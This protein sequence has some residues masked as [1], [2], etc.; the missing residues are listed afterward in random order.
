MSSSLV[1]EEILPDL[2]ELLL[3][4]AGRHQM[5]VGSIRLAEAVS[6]E[7]RDLGVGVSDLDVTHEDLP[8]SQRPR[9]SLGV[10]RAQ[11]RQRVRIYGFLRLVPLNRLPVRDLI[12][13]RR[14]PAY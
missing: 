10:D 13:L 6:H 1:L 9:A 8:A 14:A 4:L 2:C 7:L 5:I 11:L 12:P 3:E